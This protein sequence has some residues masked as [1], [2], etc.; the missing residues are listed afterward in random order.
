[1]YYICGMNEFSICIEYI[2][3]CHD[4]VTVPGL[5]TFTSQPHTSSYDTS[6][7]TL[8]P[9][10]RQVAFNPDIQHDDDF[11]L[12]AM[13]QIY[14]LPREE[15][16]RKLGM[17]IT[18]FSRT[19]AD[20]GSLDFGSVGTFTTDGGKTLFSPTLAGITTPEYYA[21]DTLHIQQIEAAGK[22]NSTPII[23]TDA[24]SIIIRINKGLV[25]NV[26]A[27]CVAMLLFFSF[28]TKVGNTEP[29]MPQHAT[30]SGLF[31]PS[32]L[33]LSLMEKESAPAKPH[34]PKETKV[35]TPATE[36]AVIPPA[37]EEAKAEADY[38][39]VMASAISRKNADNYVAVLQ[40]RGFDTARVMEG[41][42]LRVVVGEYATEGEARSAARQM[43]R[44]S[45]EYQ[46][47]WVYQSKSRQ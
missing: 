9:P 8:L 43:Q 17:W 34:T 10:Y 26:A 45:E 7:E 33:T 14:S 19:L 24:K 2:L 13:E 23:R 30:A 37:T 44:A 28:S 25:A 12:T 18:D 21:L 47:V 11:F 4:Y 46:Y 3:L 36:P 39:I 32:N 22:T 38:C 41:K 1:M 29:A 35:E 16:E 6:D 20:E 27:A 40:A 15:A 31:L 5:G 42:V